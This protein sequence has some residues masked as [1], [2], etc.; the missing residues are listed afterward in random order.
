MPG[1]GHRREAVLQ[2]VR[3]SGAPIG[4]AEIA[5]TL[6]VHPNTVRFHLDALERD[7]DIE[8]TDSA[9]GRPGRPSVRFRAVAGRGG[10]RR[11]ELLAGILLAALGDDDPGRTRAHRAGAEWGRRRARQ[12]TPVS[13][14]AGLVG[15][16]AETGFDPVA[17]GPVVE[18]HNCPFRELVAGPDDLVCAIH[19]GMMSG[20]LA[21]WG[22]AVRLESL[23][24]VPAPGPCRARL[25]GSGAAA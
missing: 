23:D 9:A 2:A 16:L 6:R 3:G 18:L 5:A 19:A 24:A 11:Y 7:G 8:R 4:V 13:P 10:S 14:V 17:N 21:T 25:V 20:A 22:E 1:Q 15:L 12:E